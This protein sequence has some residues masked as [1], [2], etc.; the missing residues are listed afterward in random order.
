MWY[1]WE[2]LF[3]EL[4]ISLYSF[5]KMLSWRDLGMN[6]GASSYFLKLVLDGESACLMLGDMVPA[7]A[8][9]SLVLVCIRLS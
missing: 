2:I 7:D 1:F 3:F 6:K 4:L 9:A 8:M 5:K